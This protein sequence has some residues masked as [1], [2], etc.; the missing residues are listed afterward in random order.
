MH[1]SLVATLAAALTLAAAGAA[2][3]GT[4]ERIRVADAGS[5]ETQAFPANVHVV[6]NAPPQYAAGPPGVWV[7]PPYW[8]TGQPE[9]RGNATMEWSVVFR[10]RALDAAR[11]AA[12]AA[13]RGWPEDQK[14]DISVP[15]VV[16]RRQVGALPGYF[17]LTAERARYEAALAV[18]I[19]TGAQAIVRFLLGSPSV[20]SSPSGTYLVLGSFLASTWN[21]GQALIALSGVR[22]EGAL[23]PKTVSIRTEP[24]RR[25]VRGRVVDPFVNPL[26]GVRVVLERAQGAGWAGVRAARTTISGTYRLAAPGRGRY[27]TVVTLGDVTAR[28]AVV[29][30]P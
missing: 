2:A 16:G 21:R 12:G 8:P 9:Q 28:S 6:L 1:G 19:G 15:L 3:A 10:D 25:I 4:V 13:A 27:R 7:G 20:D 22:V 14:S 23:P 24:T 26:V 30:L 29:P 17:V 5:P 11:A 18:P